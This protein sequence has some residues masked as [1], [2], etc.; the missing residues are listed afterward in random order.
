MNDNERAFEKFEN[1]WKSLDEIPFERE[2]RNGT[3]YYNG[4]VNVYTEKPV[5]F[6]DEEPNS[7]RGII[8][9][10]GKET[11]VVF[12]RYTYRPDIDK[13][14]VTNASVAMDGQ[15]EP[16]TLNLLLQLAGLTGLYL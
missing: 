5:R 1:V 3:G 8:L 15:L 10:I 4:A 9:P 2:W 14:L 6:Q 16:Q 12:E 7:R 13:V 11:V